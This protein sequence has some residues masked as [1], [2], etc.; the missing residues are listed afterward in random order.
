[1]M[2]TAVFAGLLLSLAACTLD[3]S[4][5]GASSPLAGGGVALFPKNGA[6]NVNPDTHLTLTFSSPPTIGTSG[7][8]R[9]YDAADNTVVDTLDMS[10]PASPNPN[11]RSTATTEAE[12]QAQ[13]RATKM[14]DYQVNTIQGVDFHF[15]PIIVRGNTATI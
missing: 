15:F 4:T 2:R 8:I 5:G 10:I 13:G 11:G 1:M 3:S 12:R 14:E 6:A 7:V 9:I